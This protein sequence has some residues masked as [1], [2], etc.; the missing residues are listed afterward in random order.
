MPLSPYCIQFDHPES[1]DQVV[2]F[3]TRTAATVSVGRDV[4]DD[5][6]NDTL[7]PDERESLFSLGFFVSSPEEEKLEMLSYVDQMNGA[8]RILKPVV[9]MNLDCNLACTYCF[10]GTRKG[11]YF[12][13]EETAADLLRFISAR[14]D[15][16]DEVRITFYGGEPL[17]SLDMVLRISLEMK[18]LAEMH[19]I[20]YGFNLITNGTLLTRRAVEQ[21]KPLGLEAATVTLDGP[22]E[23]HNLSR[24]FRSGSGSFDTVIRNLQNIRDL[25]DVHVGGNFTQT[26]YRKFPALL[27]TLIES[28]LGPGRISSV[29]FDP[30]T[31]ESKEFSPDF[32]DGCSSINEPW[33][34]EAGTFLRWEILSRGYGSEEVQPA[35]C[36]LE[37]QDHLVINYDGAIYKCPGFIGRKEFCAGT[38]KTGMRD[39]S[40][41]HNLGNWKNEECLACAYLPLCFGGC[42]Y[43]KLIRE[44]NMQG[45]D[46]KKEYFDSTLRS[47]VLQDI[48]YR[49]AAKT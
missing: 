30:V 29:R 36:M 48:K 32:H 15:G 6:E 37:R 14:I 1:P 2:L 26:N 10:E 20:V 42:R 44:D 41:I 43:M 47:L 33:L 8:S 11:K 23:V 9:V 16:K 35:V 25:I 5:I 13:S 45:V 46:C 19:G 49:K 18:S 34:A 12:L 4:A 7:S 17:L 40:V 39:Y 21:M 38:L 24:P 27:E 28:G 22:R 3:S 31:N